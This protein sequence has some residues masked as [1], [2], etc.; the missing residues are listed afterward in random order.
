MIQK[1]DGVLPENKVFSIF[2]RYHISPNKEFLS[3]LMDMLLL[4]K[5]GNIN[6]R[7][8]LTLLNWRCNLPVLPKTKRE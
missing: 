2:E 5:D 8:L 3:P 1:Y 4:R 7:E 6:Y